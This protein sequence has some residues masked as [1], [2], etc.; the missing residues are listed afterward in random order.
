M[1]KWPF[2]IR[3]LYA[4][5]KLQWKDNISLVNHFINMQRFHHNLTMS[6]QP[7]GCVATREREGW[8]MHLK[9]AEG[10]VR[11]ATEPVSFS[12]HD[13]NLHFCA[14][15]STLLTFHHHF[16]SIRNIMLTMELQQATRSIK[17]MQI[18]I[19]PMD[20]DEHFE[21]RT[22]GHFHLPF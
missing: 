14:R 20:G 22:K 8:K 1:N 2:F 4:E 3:V 11:K 21:E 18:I 12:L 19:P 16:I 10:N 5:A 7:H 13:I 15:H 9:V 6:V 17:N